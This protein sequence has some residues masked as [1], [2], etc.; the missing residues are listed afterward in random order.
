MLELILGFLAVCFVLG[1]ALAILKFIFQ[2][3][4]KIF[5]FLLVIVIFLG[6]LGGAD[7]LFFDIL[8]LSWSWVIGIV[9]TLILIFSILSS[10]AKKNRR[11]LEER[12]TDIPK[13][14][15]LYFRKNKV[16]TMEDIYQSLYQHNCIYKDDKESAH[17]SINEAVIDS[18]KD[19]QYDED[20]TLLDEKSNTESPD[21]VWLSC[22]K[23]AN[24]QQKVIQL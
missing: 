21:T 6:I 4:K 24:I 13:Y 3:L 1:I 23:T 20:I 7:Y 18:L 17:Q 11:S 12:L 10:L 2:I 16:G 5:P 8:K 15:E 19:L 9:I 14:T 22:F